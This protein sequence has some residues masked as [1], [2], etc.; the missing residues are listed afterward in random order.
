MKIRG[1]RE[2]QGAILGI[3]RAY[4]IPH[5]EALKEHLA[6]AGFDVGQATLSRDLR[7]LRLVKLPGA[8]GVSH[9]SLP[10]EWDQVP[11]LD[12]ILPTL[13]VSAEVVGNLVVIRTL[14]GGA[15][16]VASGIDWEEYE[17]LA[18]TIA[19]DDTILVILREEQSAEAIKDAIEALATRR[20]GGP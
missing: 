2:R 14:N 6:E 10:D 16:A 7:E 1:K 11:P 20:P 8:D 12:S 3:V 9:Y 19:G 15:Q 5:Q 13:F 18:G 17:G 4:R